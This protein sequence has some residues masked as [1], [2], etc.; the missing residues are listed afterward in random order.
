MPVVAAFSEGF[1]CK[2]EMFIQEEY[3]RAVIP[4]GTLASGSCSPVVGITDNRKTSFW[5][6]SAR[7]LSFFAAVI[8]SSTGSSTQQ[9]YSLTRDE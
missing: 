6:S 2:L 1:H 7:F 4:R 8:Q 9:H 5:F 3:Q